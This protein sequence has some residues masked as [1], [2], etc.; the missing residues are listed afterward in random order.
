MGVAK[1]PLH[2]LEFEDV[3]S[4]TSNHDQ[5]SATILSSVRSARKTLEKGPLSG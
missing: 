1:I 2:Y 3:I 5:S 4:V